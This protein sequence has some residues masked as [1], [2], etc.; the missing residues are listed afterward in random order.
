MGFLFCGGLFCGALFCGVLAAVPS[1][2]AAD[3]PG[4]A[5]YRE[6]CARCHGDDGVG[7]PDTPEPLVGDRSVNQLAAYIDET[8]PEDDPTKVTGEAARQ[9]ADYIHGSF[10]SAVARDRNRPARVELSRL[11]VRQYQ[12]TA[13]DLFASFRW[14]GPP[15]DDR[16][17]LRAEYFRSRD[18]NRQ[19][20]L[21]YEQIDPQVDFDFGLEGPDPERF[22]PNRFAIRWLGSIAY[23][24]SGDG[25]EYR[26]TIFLLGGR[27]YPVR[28]EFSKANQGVDNTR[29]ERPTRA[30]MRLLWKPPYGTLEPVP[31]R[32]LIPQ[33]SHEV[34]VLKT[35]FPPDDKSIGY[36]RGT[37][38]SKEWFAAATSAGV[39]IADYALDHLERLAQTRRDSPDRAAKLRTFAERFAERAFRRPLTDAL[40]KAFVEQPFA[41]APDLDTGLKRSLLLTLGSPRFLLGPSATDPGTGGDGF[42]TASRLSLGLWDSIP[43]QP[44]W[45]AASGNHLVKP[46]QVR[47]QAERMVADR[48]TRAKIRDFLFAWLRVDHGPEIVKDK[49]RY[50]EFSAEIAADLRTSLELLVDDALWGRAAGAGRSDFRR[51][52]TDDEVYVNGRIA[53]LYGVSLPP[54]ADFRRVR[55]DGGR[56]AGILSHPYMT[57]VFSYS[58]ATSPIHR[59]VFLARSVLGNVLKPPTEA[60]AP[61][62][63]DLHPNLSTRERVTLQTSSVAC[64]TCH[65]MIN[66]LGFALEEFDPIGRHRSVERRGGVDKPIDASGSYLPRQGPKATFTGARELA[67]M[68]VAS[69]DAQEA[70]VQNLFHALVKQP[71]RAWGPDTLETL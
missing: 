69:P 17:G 37:S 39:E 56:R 28:L 59:G 42:T 51:L 52:F 32:C 54:D 46:E 26:G 30:S 63:P 14:H 49:T 13:A 18:F 2:A 58:A 20:G 68:I 16:R 9:V 40:R 35:P 67:A 27:S 60:I 29:Y 15:I 23:V 11:T 3:H 44:L 21:V 12:N 47:Q 43:D 53:P 48:R 61:L 66:P 5:I 34:F 4:L 41:D 36:E 55:L 45:N 25:T 8:M 19:T 71:A 70:F 7:T 33:D 31:E 65:T 24:K 22:E 1:A 10:Y 50:S 62:A 6:H 64:Q 38:V 57:S